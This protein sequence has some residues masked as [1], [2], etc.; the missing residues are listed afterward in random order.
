MT[1]RATESKQKDKTL[2]L[3]FRGKR[4]GLIAK[5][6][7]FSIPLFNLAAVILAIILG[8]V[9][10]STSLIF[11]VIIKFLPF[12]GLLFLLGFIVPK[13]YTLDEKTF[14]VENNLGKTKILLSSVKNI[15]VLDYR[16]FGETQ[17][18]L[19]DSSGK[20]ILKVHSKRLRDKHSIKKLRDALESLSQEYGFVIREVEPDNFIYRTFGRSY[21]NLEEVTKDD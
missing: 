10:V 12:L 4:A 7:L 5:L 21:P 8:E 18:V 13:S 11:S 20:Q 15:H 2:P 3:V 14:I 19:L 17:V 6:L 9:R 1:D 16:K